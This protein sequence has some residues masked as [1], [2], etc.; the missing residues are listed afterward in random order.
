MRRDRSPE[1]WLWATEGGRH[2][3]TRLIVAT[4][5]TRGLKRGVGRETM[6][7]FFARL[8]LATQAGCSPSA[9]RGV[10]PLLEE[11]GLETA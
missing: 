5:S 6:R 11:A 7:A 10:M 4:L 9:L 2:G 3:F 8:P 1:S